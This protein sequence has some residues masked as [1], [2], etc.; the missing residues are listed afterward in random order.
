MGISISNYKLS[1]VFG[2]LPRKNEAGDVLGFIFND[3]Q[4]QYKLH[5]NYLDISHSFIRGLLSVES[6][7]FII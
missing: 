7:Y 6:K 3:S 4:Y 1:P 5:K 2:N